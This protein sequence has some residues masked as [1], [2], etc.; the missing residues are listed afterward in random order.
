MFK[1]TLL[2]LSDGMRP[3]AVKNCGHKTVERF[4]KESYYSMTMQTIMPSVTLPCHMSLIHSVPAERHGI[5]TNTYVPMVR[6]I[7]G[8]FEVLRYY[9]KK[10]GFFY[11]WEEL[12][13]LS[14]PG[15]IAYSNY[16]SAYRKFNFCNFEKTAEASSDACVKYIN[17]FESDFVFL[18]L[19]ENDAAGHDNGWMSEEYMNSVRHVWDMIEKIDSSIS[20][21]NIIVTA[22]HGGHDRMHGE[23]IPE[24]MTIPFFIKGKEINPGRFD[25]GSIID[26]APTIVKLIGVE[27]DPEWE[28]NPLI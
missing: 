18:Y 15:S 25:G 1:K 21:Y 12:R 10:S 16:F 17:E 4:F 24:D 22:D 5:T 20:G 28:G 11:D 7:N 9:G 14:R 13:D 8:L 27:A 19:G 2:I 26:I 3:D 6:P 23:N